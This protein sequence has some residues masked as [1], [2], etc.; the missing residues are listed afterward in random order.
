MVDSGLKVSGLTRH[1][2]NAN[3]P[4]AHL[5]QLALDNESQSLVDKGVYAEAFLPP[6]DRALGTRTL[7]VT[8][9][10]GTKILSPRYVDMLPEGTSLPF[11]LQMN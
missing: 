6:G 11:V 2:C 1:T 5:S 8:K 9:Q 7:L 4:D 3:R 10:D